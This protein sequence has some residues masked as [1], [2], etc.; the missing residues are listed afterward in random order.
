V[1]LFDY[2]GT[3]FKANKSWSEVRA[4]GL[5]S[6]YSLMKA[7]GLKAT[8]D[9]FVELGESVFQKYSKIEAEEDRD[10]A[11][12]VKFRDIVD[13]LFPALPDTGRARLATDANDA[14]WFAVTRN[15]PLRESAHRALGELKAA[16]LRMGVV[17][18][19]HSYESLVAHLEESGIHSHFEVVL[20]SEREGV[21]KPNAV[22]FERSLRALRVEKEHAIFVG[23]SP[24]HDIVGARKAGLG[25]VLID[26]GE[27]PEGWA[28]YAGAS[29]P[30]AKPDF[31]IR[32]LSE[33]RGIVDALNGLPADRTA[34]GP[35]R[36]PATRRGCKTKSGGTPKSARGRS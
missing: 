25:A 27:Q 12:R 10:I 32:D 3:L 30:E 19:H 34:A 4:K 9:E 20:A 24:R 16:G 2:G 18:N 14:F 15:Y 33:L 1:V 8:L 36:R 6:A 29:G 7:S 13:A 22:I 17:S 26:D 35:R 28:T 5:A 11:D 21:R 23:D 31:V